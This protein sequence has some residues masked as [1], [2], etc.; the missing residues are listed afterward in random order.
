MRGTLTS[1]LD[2][3]VDQD[4]SVCDGR[5]PV[6]VRTNEIDPFSNRLCKLTQLSVTSSVSL[7]ILMA[8]FSITLFFVGVFCDTKQLAAIG[9]SNFILTTFPYSIMIGVNTAL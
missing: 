5:S 7:L 9:F 2:Y 8:Q 3:E 6:R 4:E 1:I